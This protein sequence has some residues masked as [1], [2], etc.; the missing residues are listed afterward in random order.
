MDWEVDFQ[1]PMEFGMHALSRVY[2]V[3]HTGN[4]DLGLVTRNSPSNEFGAI[5][6]VSVGT[7]P[8]TEG[9]PP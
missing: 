7:A 2:S 9:A 1:S 6:L 5:D 3:W 4:P 8:P